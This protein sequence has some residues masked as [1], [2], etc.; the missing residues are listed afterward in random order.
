MGIFA[1]FPAFWPFLA[2]MGTFTRIRTLPQGWFYINPS[3]RGPVPGILPIF[4]SWR[5]GS[6][7]APKGPFSEISPK[8]G[9]KGVPGPGGPRPVPGSP[10]RRRAPARGVDVKP[11]SRAGPGPGSQGLGAQDQGSGP[12]GP[13]DLPGDPSG[14][15]Q[16]GPVR[17]PGTASGGCFTST[18][19]AGA[20]S[21]S[22]GPGVAAGPCPR[23]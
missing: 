7:K 6:R 8:F 19:R 12:L 2:K 9:E 13:G 10:G 17:R 4:G 1:T 16:G 3:R 23:P 21:P 11:P 18:P 20:L 14:P 22:R 5:E 15:L